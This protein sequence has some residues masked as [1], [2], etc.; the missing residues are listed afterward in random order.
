M[1]NVVLIEKITAIV[2]N[3]YEAIRVVAKEA[4]RINSLLIHG[5]GEVEEKPT[6]MAIRRLLDNK[7]KFDYVE[8]AVQA[9]FEKDSE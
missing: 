5:A 4:R 6:M 2:P 1:K 8:P 9:K 7:I 3:K